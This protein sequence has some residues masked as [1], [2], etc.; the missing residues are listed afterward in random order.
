MYRKEGKM[1]G[2]L[3]I[4]FLVMALIGSAMSTTPTF[5]SEPVVTWK[6]FSPFF[7]GTVEIKTVQGWTEDISKMSGGRIKI[8]LT[9]S[10]P[11]EVCPD[12]HPPVQSGDIDAAYTWP[13]L[14]IGKYPA[15]A[16]FAETP[17]FFDLMGYFTWMYAYGGKELWQEIY[18]NTLKIF[19]AGICW[20]KVGGWTNKKLETMDDFKG[21]KYRTSDRAWHRTGDLIWG[22]I[23]SDLG[24]SPIKDPYP[25]AV[26]IGFLKGTL[27]VVEESTPWVDMSLRF[28]EVVKS[29]YF[30]GIQDM[31][32][33]LEL[34]VNNEKWEALPSDLKEIVKG[35]C[36][37]T[38][39]R[40]LT[41]WALDDAKAIKMLRD[42]RKVNISKFSKEI[43]REILDRFVAQYDAVNDSMFQKVW[44]SQ[45]EFM[46]IYV[47]YMRLQQADAD[48][49]LK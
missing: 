27:D 37:V 19:P 45:K 1:K 26:R 18:G 21:L 15:A 14:V 10:A 49:K 39:A 47:P 6:V 48:A 17:A 38:M 16:L 23:L 36:D 29:C 7:P 11:G 43:Q 41:H 28:H 33:F 24:A 5:A 12:L 25:Q 42:E 44:K 30:P 20:A 22:K 9:S 3:F 8:N 31:A 32:T 46:K 35:A 4:G 2:T 13:G 34:I 40:S